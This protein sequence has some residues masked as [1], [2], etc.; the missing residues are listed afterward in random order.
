MTIELILQ[1]EQHTYFM[2]CFKYTPV[3]YAS[4]RML[5]FREHD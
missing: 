1:I 3:S 2:Y 5:M 4:P